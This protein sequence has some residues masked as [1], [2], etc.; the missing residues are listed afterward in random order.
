VPS[1]ET[2]AGTYRFAYLGSTT[3][4]ARY[5]RIVLRDSRVRRAI[6]RI[7]T[8]SRRCQRLITLNIATLITPSPARLP[9]RTVSIRGSNLNA[10]H[11][12]KWVSFRRKSTPGAQS[13]GRSRATAASFV[14]R[15]DGPGGARGERA[16]PGDCDHRGVGRIDQNLGLSIDQSK[17]SLTRKH[18]IELAPRPELEPGACGLTERR[19]RR[20]FFITYQ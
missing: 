17:C 6:S 4:F 19:A 13:Y 3:A 11:P 18:L 15:A 1:F 7:D 10:N 9:S 20:R 16:S 14:L 12:L 5:F 8:P 2:R